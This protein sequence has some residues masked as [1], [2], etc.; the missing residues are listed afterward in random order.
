M[1]VEG[2]E[3]EGQSGRTLPC[4]EGMFTD[5]QPAVYRHHLRGLL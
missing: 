5:A 1:E 3:D 2:M 4:S